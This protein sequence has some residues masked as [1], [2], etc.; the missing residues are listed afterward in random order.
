[1]DTNKLLFQLKRMDKTK[2]DE[3]LDSLDS[4]LS[5]EQKE[6]LVGMVR[7]KQID[8]LISDLLKSEEVQK[9]ISDLLG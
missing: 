8:G 1:V 2:R 6:K 4:A 7:S 9:K 5:D 3:M